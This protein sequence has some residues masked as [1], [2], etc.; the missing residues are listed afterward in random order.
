[1]FRDIALGEE[2]CRSIPLTQVGRV[3]FDIDD[4][5]PEGINTYNRRRRRKRLIIPDPPGGPSTFTTTDS[6]VEVSCHDSL[7]TNTEC[8]EPADDGSNERWTRL[9]FEIPDVS[10]LVFEFNTHQHLI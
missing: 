7:I 6:G 4:A 5:A 1:M 8:G 10:L 2:V 3:T 9:S